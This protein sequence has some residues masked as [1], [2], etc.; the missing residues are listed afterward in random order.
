LDEARRCGEYSLS[1]PPLYFDQLWSKYSGGKFGFSVQQR[2]YKSLDGTKTYD[3]NIWG[4]FADRIGWKEKDMGWL[5]YDDLNFSKTAPTGQLPAYFASNG[6]FMGVVGI[7]M[8]DHLPMQ[9][10]GVWFM[11]RNAECNI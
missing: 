8:W 6:Y 3:E 1:R 11:S 5:R 4:S 10:K 2:I 9:V 7:E